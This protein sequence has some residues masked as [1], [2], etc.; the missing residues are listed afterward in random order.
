MPVYELEQGSLEYHIHSMDVNK[1]G[2][3]AAASSYAKNPTPKKIDVIEGF[4]DAV[5]DNFEAAVGQIIIS[6]S[7]H[8]VKVQTI[9]TLQQEENAERVK[10]LNDI[11]G[12]KLLRVH[13]FPTLE[14]VYGENLEYY[15]EPEPGSID[16]NE[17]L[18]D[19]TNDFYASIIDDIKSFAWF[20][21]KLKEK[22]I[23]R[24]KALLEKIQGA[25]VIA[26]GLAV[27]FYMSKKLDNGK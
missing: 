4:A 12:V 3:Y 21:A 13:S 25:A 1:T 20:Y 26:G 23:Q 8:L 14:D 18:N 5:T 19:S 9:Q 6:D 11:I 22:D 17:W 16:N 10:F 24:K 2:M 15:F 7:S 27:G